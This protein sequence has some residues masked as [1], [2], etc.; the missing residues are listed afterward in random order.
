MALAAGAAAAKEGQP[1]PWQLGLQP[2][3]STI[4]DGIVSF[5]DLLLV[6]IALISAF[7]L[8][9]MFYVGVRFR[10]GANPVPSRTSHNTVV[11]VLWTVIPVLILVAV[12]IPSFRLLYFTDVT[13]QAEMTIKAIGRQWDWSYE[14]PDHGNFT[15]DALITDAKDLKPGQPRLLETDNH[16]VVP[17][18]ANIRVL[19]TAA[20]V[21]HAWAVPAFGV[22]KDGYPGR[23]NETWFR[24]KREGIYYGQC[25]ELCGTNHGF[26]PITVEV[27]SRE[28]FARWAADAKKKFASADRAAIA[29]AASGRAAD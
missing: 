13:P 23:L 2:S 25:S 27:V 14:Y 3:G 9:L 7:V 29:V 19:V 16:V 12:A 20:D 5:H 1:S 15:F 18:N 11:E 28:A 6:I 22:K 4:M 10:A 26:M 8:A 24:A 21:A 17:V